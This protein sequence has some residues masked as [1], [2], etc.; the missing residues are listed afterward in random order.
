MFYQLRVAREKDGDVLEEFLKQAK[1]NYEGVKEGFTQFLMLEDSEKNIAGCL[2]IEKIS[3]DQGSAA[4][5]CDIGQASPRP[6]CDALS[7]HGTAV[8]KASDQNSILNSESA[9]LC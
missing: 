5:T 7:E 1:T 9:F 8:R 4:I 6:Y 3:C 2:G